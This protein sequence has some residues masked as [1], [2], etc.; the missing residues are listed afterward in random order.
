L[1]FEKSLWICDSKQEE[2][3]RER[4]RER[5]R[6]RYTHTLA[7]MVQWWLYRFLVHITYIH[8]SLSSLCILLFSFLFF[9]TIY[10]LVSLFRIFRRCMCVDCDGREIASSFLFMFRS[11]FYTSRI[12]FTVFSY[13]LSASNF[14]SEYA[15]KGKK[16]QKKN[17][18]VVFVCCF[19][20]F[21]RILF[22]S[23]C[24]EMRWRHWRQ[25]FI[26]LFLNLAV[27]EHKTRIGR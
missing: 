22:I 26:D 6:K 13:Y 21:W 8:L 17:Y 11:M 12:V 23:M 25:R 2:G 20:F 1:A 9:N 27:E 18:E 15:K 5:E 24:M 16:M 10:C 7:A 4:E 19:E 3:E 14:S